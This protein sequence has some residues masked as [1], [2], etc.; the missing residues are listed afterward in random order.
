[1]I[2]TPTDTTQ[3]GYYYQRV[4]VW[5]RR[6]GMIPPVPHPEA[7]HVPDFGGGCNG[8]CHNGGCPGACGIQGEIISDA[9]AE[10]NSEPTE[11]A[12]H[13]AAPQE[14]APEAPP[15][16]DSTDSTPP[17]AAPEP[18]PAEAPPALE[19]SA[20]APFLYAIPKN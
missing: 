19:K 11:S 13:P 17:A 12:P 1:M 20:L 7:F 16:P 18:P 9:P 14:A 2:Y 8:L 5:Q 6:N 4:P 10:G 3:L 15:V